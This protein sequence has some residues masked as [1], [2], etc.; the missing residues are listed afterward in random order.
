MCMVAS[1][2]ITIYTSVT[3][4]EPKDKSKEVKN[5]MYHTHSL[6]YTRKHFC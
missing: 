4:S 5:K 3:T 1:A 6:K 2:V